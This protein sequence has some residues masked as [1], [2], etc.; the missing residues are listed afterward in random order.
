MGLPKHKEGTFTY[1][2]YLQWPDEQRWE[3]I[4]GIAYNMSPAPGTAHQRVVGEVFRRIAD[5]TDNGPCE[6][7]I[8]PFD[9]RLSAGA[10]GETAEADEAVETVVQPDISVFCDPEKTDERGAKGAPDLVV[11][12]LSPATAHKDQTE[13]LRLY[14]ETG[15]REFWIVNAEAAY[16]MVY[17]RGSSGGFGKPDYYTREER[18]DSEVLNA[19]IALSAVFGK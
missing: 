15:V 1:A 11:E 12:V 13:K 18:V 9:V 17:R 7:F 5:L 10:P 3:L 2:D 4:H 19:S 16:V 8:A 14:E 6:T